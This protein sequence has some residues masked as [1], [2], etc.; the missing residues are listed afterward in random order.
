MAIYGRESE[1]G[2]AITAA[3]SCELEQTAQFLSLK[4]IAGKASDIEQGVLRGKWMILSLRGIEWIS[5][6]PLMNNVK[7]I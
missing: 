4:L 6:S 1:S 7:R 2:A 3:A 5:K